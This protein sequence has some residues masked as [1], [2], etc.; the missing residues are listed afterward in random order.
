[1]LQDSS[2]SGVSIEEEVVGSLGG[3]VGS[4]TSPD[5]CRGQ[6]SIHNCVQQAL[7]LEADRTAEFLYLKDLLCWPEKRQEL[8]PFLM[9]S[10]VTYS[11]L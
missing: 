10:P 11:L 4:R 2:T 1:L 6:N 5:V 3:L 9:W 8:E 7:S